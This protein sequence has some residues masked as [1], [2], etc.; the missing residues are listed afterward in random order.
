M[1][2]EFISN[3][4]FVL[5]KK[6]RHIN[7]LINVA[8]IEGYNIKN[9]VYVFLTDDELKSLN[10]KYLNHDYYTDVLSFNDSVGKDI[11]G[12]IAISI[13]RVKENAK[14]YSPSFEEELR[15]VMVHGLLHFMNY[16]D[17][18]KEEVALIRAKEEKML[19]L[20]HVKQ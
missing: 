11:K 10:I 3:I 15:R 2:I 18:T 13:Q 4:D 8:N 16:K 9:V 6:K 12:D 17:S 19:G 5:N 1:P 14:L 20:F 7:W